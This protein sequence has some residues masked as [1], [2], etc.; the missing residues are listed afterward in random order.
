MLEKEQGM[1]NM[2]DNDA[3]TA[4]ETRIMSKTLNNI[5]DNTPFQYLINIQVPHYQN[6]GL[7]TCLIPT[8]G[9]VNSM[10]AHHTPPLNAGISN[11]NV[12][13]GYSIPPW[14]EGENWTQT[15]GNNQPF[16]NKSWLKQ[17]T[18]GVLALK[19]LKAIK[20]RGVI[21]FSL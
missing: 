16:P 1:T 3:I 7:P 4:D 12:R 17:V 11:A 6:G 10:Y 13:Y 5:A 21:C 18:R 19:I 14:L 9:G 20:N 2:V 15:Y 8:R